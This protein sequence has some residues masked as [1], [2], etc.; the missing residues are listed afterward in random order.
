MDAMG[1]FVVVFPGFDPDSDALGL[2]AD[3]FNSA[4]QRVNESLVQ[5]SDREPSV[6]MDADG[7]FVIT[8]GTYGQDGYNV[9]AQ[10]YNSAGIQQGEAFHVNGITDAKRPA[11]AMDSLGNFVV[12]YSQSRDNVYARRYQVAVQFTGTPASDTYLLKRDTTGNAIEVFD[13]TDPSAIPIYS[14][15][16]TKSVPLSFVTDSEKDTLSFD[17]SNESPIP[18]GGISIDAGTDTDT[19]NFVGTTSGSINLTAGSFD[20]ASDP[21]GG[22][23]SVSDS[24]IANLDIS[25]RLKSLSLSGNGE[26]SLLPGGE[27]FLRASSLSISDSA[28]LDLA[29]KDLIID[30]TV[31]NRSALLATL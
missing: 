25:S 29:D 13:S 9:Y 16:L 20:I 15:L 27:K 2:Y 22:S 26:L 7:D 14:V 10:R 18:P 23:F 4:G 11:V 8:W 24:A 1:N 19:L 5:H 17:L 31:Q 12:A 6:A 28:T 30:S 21:N 3:R